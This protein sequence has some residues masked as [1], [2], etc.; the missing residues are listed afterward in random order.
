MIKKRFQYS[1]QS[2]IDAIRAV[3]KKDESVS[4]ASRKYNVP[5]STLFD[6]LTQKNPERRTVGPG[7]ILSAEE[8][9]V[10]ATWV[11]SM[12]K[13]GFPI[14]KSQLLDSV[15]NFIVK[16]KRQTCFTNNRPG[17]KWYAKFL[18][19]HPN[20]VI[21]KSQ[22]LTKSLKASLSEPKI[23]EWFNEIHTFLK[24]ESLDKVLL[25]PSRIWNTYD[26]GFSL[27]LKDDILVRKGNQLGDDKDCITTL[28]MGKFFFCT[29]PKVKTFFLLSK[30]CFYV[31]FR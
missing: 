14:T 12:T 3:K 18:T 28:F 7:T 13:A 24:N 2:M 20:L 15:Q 29:F 10:F 30:F 19:R 6:K 4:S 9:Q 11:E 22:S 5:R 17:R 21:R 16:N 23:R 1:E 26:I 27:Y 31:F 25:E 8:E